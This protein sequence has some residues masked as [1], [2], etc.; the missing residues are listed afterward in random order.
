MAAEIKIHLSKELKEKFAAKAKKSD[1]S[2]TAVVRSLI[3]NYV[4]KK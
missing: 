1:K 2:M 3:H 4:E